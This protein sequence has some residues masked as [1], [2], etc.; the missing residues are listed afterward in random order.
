MR[1]ENVGSKAPGAG[2]LPGSDDARA[3][4]ALFLQ[5]LES[6]FGKD[7]TALM[8]GFLLGRYAFGGY[9]HIELQIRFEENESG[10]LEWIVEDYDAET[11]RLTGS[12]TGKGFNAFVENFGPILDLDDKP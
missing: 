6:V 11:K 2:W 4:K 3:E 10:E 7:R 9:G 5:E 8:D 12:S 1:T